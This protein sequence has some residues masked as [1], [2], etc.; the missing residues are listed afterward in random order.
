[1][2]YISKNHEDIFLGQL[3][4]AFVLHLGII[5][6]AVF[7]SCSDDTSQPNK[8]P[9][10]EITYPIDSS[11]FNEDDDITFASISGDE[12]DGSLSDDSLV[13][14]SSINGRIGIGRSISRNNLS[15]GTHTI[16]LTATD[17]Q[18]ATGSNSVAITI[19]A[20]TTSH[21]ITNGS[22]TIGVTNPLQAFDGDKSTAATIGWYGGEED[23]SDY[24]HFVAFV[25]KDNRFT[26][27]IS[28]GASSPGSLVLIEGETLPDTWQEIYRYK[29][30]SAA[31]KIIT[32]INARQF[33]D[34]NG[35]ISLRARWVGG[36]DTDS[37][38]IFEISRK[39]SP[40]TPTTQ[41][42]RVIIIDL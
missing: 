27:K 40:T 9:I 30:D 24:L 26:F 7:G 37:C 28:T 39:P 42:S 35:Y 29:L 8:I 4:I 36:S 25:G 16:T 34:A 38:S 6:I 5:I 14:T 13:W 11:I 22:K 23:H 18:G 19:K 21:P 20:T 15:S 2:K 32:V 12:E 3:W 10:V 31:T 17:S 1:V 33:V 41:T